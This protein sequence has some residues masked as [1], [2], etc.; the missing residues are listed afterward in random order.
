MSTHASTC[1]RMS[2]HARTHTRAHEHARMSTHAH[3]HEHARISMH[4][5]MHARMS[6]HTRMSTHARTHACVRAHTLT[7]RS[8]GAHHH[9]LRLQRRRRTQEPLL[10]VSPSRLLL[11]LLRLRSSASSRAAP[12]QSRSA[13][14]MLQLSH[15]RRCNATHMAHTSN[16]RHCAHACTHAL[17]TCT[18]QRCTH[19]RTGARQSRAP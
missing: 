1:A 5:C 15:S 4:A 11:Q 7:G 12:L 18:R 17:H 10:R 13:P 9:R 16:T 3:T 19:A 14:Q 6:T 8:W 2:T